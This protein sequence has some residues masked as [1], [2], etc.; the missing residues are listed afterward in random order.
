LSIVARRYFVRGRKAFDSGDLE[1]AMESL[2]AAVDL[3]PTFVAARVAYAQALAGFGDC[4]RAAQSLRSGLAQ[5]TTAPG[6]GELFS[7][8]G[9]VLTRS[10]DFRGAEEAF[11]QAGQIAGFEGRAAAG[12]ARIYAKLGRY[13]EAFACLAT[14]ARAARP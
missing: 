12:R 8:L 2:R 10:G 11:D 7:A 3:V 4:P 5:R 13:A 6:R 14:A 1:T 9:D